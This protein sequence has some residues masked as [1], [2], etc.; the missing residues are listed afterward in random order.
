MDP[1]FENVAR[2]AITKQN[3]TYTDIQIHFSIDY[4]RAVKLF[5]MLHCF[6]VTEKPD[7]NGVS[8][9]KCKGEKALKPLLICARQT[10]NATDKILDA[11]YSKSKL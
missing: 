10:E 11:Y 6:S 2:Y 5:K 9:V 4:N 7:V 3:L 8:V 1:L